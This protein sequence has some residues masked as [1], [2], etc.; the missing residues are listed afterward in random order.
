M[1]AMDR[2]R[3]GGAALLAGLV[4]G[5]GSTTPAPKAQTLNQSGYSDTFKQGYNEG[6]ESAGGRQRRNEGRYKTEADYMMGWNDGFSACRR[7]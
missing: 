1:R 6:C 4:A 5:C 3:L 2:I 7:R